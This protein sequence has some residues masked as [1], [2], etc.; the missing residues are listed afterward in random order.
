MTFDVDPKNLTQGLSQFSHRRKLLAHSSDFF[1]FWRGLFAPAIL[2][3]PFFSQFILDHL[4]YYSFALLFL[5]G[6]TNYILHLHIH[7]PF[8]GR[9]SVNLLLDLTMAA[10]TGMTASN[11]RIQHIEGH[12]RGQEDIFR[13]VGHKK[14]TRFSCFN[15]VS[16][17]FSALWPSFWQPILVAARR[18]KQIKSA[19]L[20]DYWAF[21]EQAALILFFIILASWRPALAFCYIL[22]WWAL[23]YFMTRYVDFLNHFGCDEK[24]GNP[25]LCANNSLSPTYNFLT[26]NFGYHTAHHCRP[27]AHWTQLPEIHKRLSSRIPKTQLKSYSWSCALMPW[28]FYLSLRGRM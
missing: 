15:A 18:L 7:R 22:P 3:A 19:K 2:F 13:G 11:W 9:P 21:I 14:L 4:A 10:A 17:A 8:S 20:S 24:S 27:S 16:Y 26:N 6:N 1:L 28:H 12:H 25:L 23:N 5:I